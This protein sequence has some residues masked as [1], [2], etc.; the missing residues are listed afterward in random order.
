MPD[1]R[2]FTVRIWAERVGARVEHRGSVRAVGGGAFRNFREWS[3]LTS[4]LAQQLEEDAMEK[5]GT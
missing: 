4:F 5:E 1:D 2:V 3:D